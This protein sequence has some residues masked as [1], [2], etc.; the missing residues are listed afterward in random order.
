MPSECKMK[1]FASLSTLFIVARADGGESMLRARPNIG[2]GGDY[3]RRGT[4]VAY[5]CE[6]LFRYQQQYRP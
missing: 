4:N 6:Q 3:A 2:C 1:N 5:L